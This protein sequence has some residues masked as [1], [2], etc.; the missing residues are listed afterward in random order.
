MLLNF[1]NTEWKRVG[2]FMA[3]VA[4]FASEDANEMLADVYLKNGIAKNSVV[5]TDYTKF[6]S[7]KLQAHTF[8]M[9]S[10][11]KQRWPQTF[12]NA[13]AQHFITTANNDILVKFARCVADAWRGTSVFSAKRYSTTKAI[14]TLQTVSS[15]HVLFFKHVKMDNRNNALKLKDARPMPPLPR[16]IYL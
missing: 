2:T 4:A 10:D 16:D 6:M 15:V 9:I 14:S 8:E 13:A 1:G 7:A 12:K 5:G 3:Y 11:I